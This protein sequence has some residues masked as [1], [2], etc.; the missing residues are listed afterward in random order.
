MK[1]ANILIS[2]LLLSLS[3][4]TAQTM[5]DLSE[6]QM[7]EFNRRKLIVEKV[8]E[9]TRRVGL[10][11]R[12]LL[13]NIDAWCAFRGST[14]PANEISFEDFF[15]IAGYN[16]EAELVEINLDVAYRKC[17]VGGV[18]SIAGITGMCYPKTETH[19]E[20]SLYYC[21]LGPMQIK[22]WE[23]ITHPM[24]VPGALFTILGSVIWYQGARERLQPGIPYQ[25][26][27]DIADEY[28]NRLMH[29]IIN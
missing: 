19:I 17:G 10:S 1:I 12:L 6:E 26:A 9:S 16:E 21:G 4:V 18:F 14:A 23:E 13:R 5:G 20:R 8:S 22:E 25:T 28:N 29:E 3:P 27:A 2:V 11:R 7:L 24:L 15:R